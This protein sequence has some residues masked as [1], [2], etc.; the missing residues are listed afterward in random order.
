MALE[1]GDALAGALDRAPP[2]AERERLE[3][4]IRAANDDTRPT[5]FWIGGL[6]LRAC[7]GVAV[8]SDGFESGDLAGWSTSAP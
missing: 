6:G 1:R 2:A 3:P 5:E 7:L 8:F 4:E